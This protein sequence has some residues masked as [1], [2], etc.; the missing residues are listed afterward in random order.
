MCSSVKFQAALFTIKCL[1]TW[2]TWIFLLCEIVTLRKCTCETP[3][4]RYFRVWTGGEHPG[5]LSIA[6]L[7]SHPLIATERKSYLKW[8][9]LALYLGTNTGSNELL[10]M[11]FTSLGNKTTS[12]GDNCFDVSRF[13]FVD[14]CKQIETDFDRSFRHTRKSH[15]MLNNTCDFTMV[16]I[17]IFVYSEHS[18]SFWNTGK[19]GEVIFVFRMRGFEFMWPVWVY[20]CLILYGGI[21]VS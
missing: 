14:D 11:W 10:N 4:Y 15:A 18:K 5:T 16:L 17:P 3:V 20:H 1:T 12:I 2:T 8:T 7:N 21:S 13:L 9:I 19:S 6:I